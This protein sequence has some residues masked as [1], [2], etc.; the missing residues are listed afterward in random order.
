MGTGPANIPEISPWS[1]PWKRWFMTEVRASLTAWATGEANWTQASMLPS[2]HPAR[3]KASVWP[4]AGSKEQ[5]VSSQRLA[6]LM[7]RATRSLSSAVTA[8][9]DWSALVRPRA[10]FL[11]S[12]RLMGPRSAWACMSAGVFSPPAVK[13]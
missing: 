2:I 13:A 7:T 6:S 11:A 1:K 5:T 8:V 12:T 4:G 10:M 9:S 3:V